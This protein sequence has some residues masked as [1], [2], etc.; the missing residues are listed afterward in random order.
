MGVGPP[1]VSATTNYV[2]LNEATCHPERSEGASQLHSDRAYYVYLMASRTRVLYVGTTS[3]LLRRVFQH[4]NGAFA[5]FTRKYLVN[6]LVYFARTPNN[7]AAVARERQIKGRTRE[8][9]FR[10]VE[11]TNLGW[12]DLAS[13]W[14]RTCQADPSLRS[15]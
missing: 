6:R 9:K 5:G 2:I 4:K 13:G 3:D 1:A 7:R 8:K 11:T 14:F 12:E 15:G 10:L